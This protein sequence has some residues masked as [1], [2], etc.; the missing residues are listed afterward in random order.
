MTSRRVRVAAT[1]AAL[2]LASAA[3]AA[4]RPTLFV[5]NLDDGTITAID[6]TTLRV[7]GHLDAIPDGSTPQD[8]AQAAVYGALVAAKGRNYV[9]GLAVSPDARTLYVS[10]GFLGDVIAYDIARR[11]ILW[12][13][14]IAGI[15]ADHLALSPDGRRLFVSALTQNEVEAI[16]TATHAVI[17]TF[18]TGDWPHV[19]EFT[20]DG[21]HVVNG[22]LGDQLL[23]AGAP[24]HFQIT[25]A[26][27]DTLAVQRVFPYDAGVRPFAFGPDARQAYVQFSFF[28][29]FRE[30]DMVTGAVVRTK[31]LPVQG[32]EIG[33]Q[34]SDYPNQAAHHGID[35]GPGARTVCD[36]STVGNYVALVDRATL[37]TRE[38]TH[39]PAGPAEA[40]TSADGRYCLVSDREAA[41]LSV[42]DYATG[43]EVA[44][45][46]TGSR[47][48]E[49]AQADVPDAVLRQAGLTLTPLPAARPQRR[50]R[51][52][53][54][55]RHRRRHHRRRHPR[56]RRRG[57]AHAH[58]RGTAR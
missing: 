31:L 32:P 48:Q 4:A 46:P 7:M 49:Q 2:A 54:V 12:R 1:A 37:Q 33:M 6:T 39:V 11:A 36:A 50:G 34:R 13:V 52:G 16:D 47:P 29:G 56:R 15:R 38:I 17:G 8:P 14:Q 30:I 35:L 24:T 42:I 23:P 43:R 20:P 21:R 51:P 27:P 25:V 57:H 22:S 44:R 40:Q 53:P 18:P 3:P 55:R 19:L 10:R 41:S 58:A 28:D 45:L 9:Q 5:G 26:D